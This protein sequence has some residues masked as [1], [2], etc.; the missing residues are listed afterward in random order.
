MLDQIRIK[1]HGGEYKDARFNQKR[2]YEKNSL[3]R[4]DKRK[5]QRRVK[6]QKRLKTSH[7]SPTLK[8]EQNKGEKHRNYSKSKDRDAGKEDPMAQLMALKGKSKNLKSRDVRIVKEDDLEDDDLSDL[9]RVESFDGLLEEEDC[10]D[11]DED[12]AEEDPLEALEGLKAGNLKATGPSNGKNNSVELKRV[13]YED[14]KHDFASFDDVDQSED[15]MGVADKEQLSFQENLGGSSEEEKEFGE[16]SGEE[17]ED[18]FSALRKLKE[19]KYK[20]ALN[21]PE[22]KLYQTKKKKR[23]KPGKD[24]EANF[25]DP[26]ENDLEFYARKLGLKDGKRAKLEKLDNDDFVGGL[27]EGLEFD[28]LD[29]SEDSEDNDDISGEDDSGNESDQELHQKKENPFVAP[30]NDSDS[31]ANLKKS[32]S[33]LSKYIPPALRK[34]LALEN[35]ETST[36]TFAL[37]RAIKG[38]LNKL[39]ESN[40]GTIVNEIIQLYLSYPRQMVT[41]NLTQ[42]L[43]DSVVLQTRLLDNFVLLHAALIVAIYRLQGADCG[44]NFVQTLVEEYELHKSNPDE[45]KEALNCAAFLSGIFT[46]HLISSKLL[47][48]IIRGLI[49]DFSETNA[50]ILLRV[51]RNSG[52]QMRAEDP[53]SLKEIVF[54]V[55]AKQSALPRDQITPRMQF[56][57]DT[58]ISLKNNKLTTANSDSLQTAVRLKKYLGSFVSSKNADPLQVT[59]DDIRSI[60]AKGKWW[61]VGSAWKGQDDSATALVDM[62][63]VSD[64]LEGAEPNWLELARTQRM[65]TDVRRAI[66]ISIMSA[67][68]YLDAATKLDKLALKRTQQREIPRILIHC[69]VVEPAWNPYYGILAAKLCDLHSYRKTFQFLLWDLIRSFDS[70]SGYGDESDEENADTFAGF[71]Y[72]QTN[73]DKLKK[74]MNLGRLFGHLFAESSLALHLLCTVN[75]V[76]ATADVELFLEILLVTFYDL[77]AKKSQVHSIGIGLGKKGMSEQKFHDHLLIERLLKAKGEPALLKGLNLFSNRRLLNS[78]FILGKKQR[79]RVEWG[80]K[81][82]TDV[83]DEFVKEY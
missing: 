81:C 27:L 32:D 40:L 59:L 52:N 63:A 44:A 69:A 9:E 65:N 4:K 7:G 33:Q 75:F 22:Q 6:K 70:S 19:A 13:K 14:F 24:I 54:L 67:S 31:D 49:S 38:P 77:L 58:I 41:E 79:K 66:F 18:S 43:M 51:I 20:Q 37:Q 23:T 5:E 3:S 53:A 60:E 21:E 28:Y 80:V 15:D 64:V 72:D 46:F 62:V 26:Y 50:E 8:Q 68:D 29:K 83:I 78:D 56:L 10:D 57:M 36:G 45:G 55:I 2:K 25:V 74:L 34:K 48:D 71:D 1:E 76:T 42:I 35:T 47:F 82:A 16:L 30:S 12:L 73:D 39:S 61:L 11:L 17:E